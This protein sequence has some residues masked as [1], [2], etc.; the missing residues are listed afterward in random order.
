MSDDRA[1]GA[2]NHGSD[3]RTPRGRSSL[4]ADYPTDRGASRR[5]DYRSFLLLIHAR[6]TAHPES[7]DQEKRSQRAE[8]L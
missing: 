4:I 2:T 1:G 8:R 7:A 5:A 3:D 6:A